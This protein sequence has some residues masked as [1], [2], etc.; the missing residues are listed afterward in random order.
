MKAIA[1]VG[2]M[3]KTELPHFNTMNL[4]SFSPQ[5]IPLRSHS[6]AALLPPAGGFPYPRFT[7]PFL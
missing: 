2:T 1:K 5:E 6:G 3:L 7:F 4:L